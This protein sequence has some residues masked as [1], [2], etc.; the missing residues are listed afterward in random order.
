MIRIDKTSLASKKMLP[1][2]QKQ[3]GLASLVSAYL[4]PPGS[5]AAIG[6]FRWIG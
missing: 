2:E 5:Q 6:L 3:R 1:A 4:D